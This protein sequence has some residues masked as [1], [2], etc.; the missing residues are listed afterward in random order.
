VVNIRTLEGGVDID[1]ITN[2]T[3]SWLKDTHAA[4]HLG[5]ASESDHCRRTTMLYD[6][7]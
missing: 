6:G 4:F 5:G 2:G 1:H 7:L 3:A